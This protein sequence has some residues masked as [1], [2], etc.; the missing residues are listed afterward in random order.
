MYYRYSKDKMH[1]VER[2]YEMGYDTAMSEITECLDPVKRQIG[3][4][5]V[6]HTPETIVLRIKK[7]IDRHYEISMNGICEADQT[8]LNNM[9]FEVVEA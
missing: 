6:E 1:I 3:V 5:K 7:V 4:K 8:R 2:A 9:K